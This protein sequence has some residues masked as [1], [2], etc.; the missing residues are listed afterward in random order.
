MPWLGFSHC[1]FYWGRQSSTPCLLFCLVPVES[2]IASF[3][4]KVCF[5]QNPP[6]I[7]W[8]SLSP[9]CVAGKF[10]TQ[11]STG[12]VVAALRDGMPQSGQQCPVLGSSQVCTSGSLAMTRKPVV[13]I[14]DVLGKCLCS[15][16][17]RRRQEGS[18]Q[19]WHLVC[20]CH[21]TSVHDSMWVL[22][23]QLEG[24]YAPPWAFSAFVSW[25]L[26]FGNT[27]VFLFAH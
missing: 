12:G 16:A 22:S 14:T 11:G 20:G 17:H 6:I 1:G 7:Q 23:N 25:M 5:W 15:G 13:P 4:V 3:E 10:C 24:F 19:Q 8:G 2:F 18:L 9:C 27:H 21:R 26:Q